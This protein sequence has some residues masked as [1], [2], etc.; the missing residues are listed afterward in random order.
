[1]N[2]LQHLS[3]CFLLF[4]SLV[5]SVVCLAVW[6]WGFVGSGLQSLV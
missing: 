2:L 1:M 6:V 3:F 5:W 4:S